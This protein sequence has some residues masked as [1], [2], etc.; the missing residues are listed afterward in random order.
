MEIIGFIKL[1]LFSGK[2]VAHQH[3]ERDKSLSDDF[4]MMKLCNILEINIIGLLSG[5]KMDKVQK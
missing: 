1:V 2:I 4:I 5:Y 3:D